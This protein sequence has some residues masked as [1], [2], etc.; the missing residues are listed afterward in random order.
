V[1]T[2]VSGGCN[3]VF[4]KLTFSG[5]NGPGAVSVPGVKAGDL[6][7]WMSGNLMGSFDGPAII[8]TDDTINQLT[9][10]DLSAYSIVAML[11]RWS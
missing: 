2:L 8:Q 4:L 1:S 9:G 10:T 11:A 7:L 5:R 6:I 3:P